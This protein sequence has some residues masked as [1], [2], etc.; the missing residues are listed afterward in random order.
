MKQ[1]IAW[2]TWALVTWEIYRSDHAAA[3][4]AIVIGF[5]VLW[6]VNVRYFAL[7]RAGK[8]PRA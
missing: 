3:A 8:H 5:I 6:A 1:A 2:I 7:I 4:V